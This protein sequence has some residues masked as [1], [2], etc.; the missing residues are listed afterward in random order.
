MQT[1]KYFI[2]HLT[3][4][5]WKPLTGEVVVD[6]KIGLNAGRDEFATARGTI[7]KAIREHLFLY[8]GTKATLLVNDEHLINLEYAD[9]KWLESES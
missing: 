8:H 1:V 5:G 6:E 2:T 4:S 3:N 7:K 9:G